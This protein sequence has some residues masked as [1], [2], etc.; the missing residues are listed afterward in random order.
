[1]ALLPP[2]SWSRRSRNGD[3]MISPLTVPVILGHSG[4]AAVPSRRKLESRSRGTSASDGLGAGPAPA[5]RLTAMK[6]TLQG[7]FRAECGSNSLRYT[8]FSIT[9]CHANIS[10][11]KSSIERE[12]IFLGNTQRSITRS[13]R[14]GNK[15]RAHLHNDQKDK[16][17]KRRNSLS[18]LLG[19]T[20]MIS[21]N[22]F[23]QK[24]STSSAPIVQE[25]CND[26]ILRR[27]REEAWNMAT[28]RSMFM[29]AQ[30]RHQ[31]AKLPNNDD[32][33]YD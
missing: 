30:Y 16:L 10:K 23:A 20:P 19:L 26:D 3:S 29:I 9:N 6:N 28:R 18:R 11:D 2:E 1:M 4:R 14:P 33:S 25:K 21:I 13:L 22:N 7:G 32:I 27:T 17:K 12:L 5:Y 24:G 15:N 31:V 8:H